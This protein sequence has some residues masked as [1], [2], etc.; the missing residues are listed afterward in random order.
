MKLILQKLQDVALYPKL[1]RCVFHQSQMEFLEYI[2]F[3]EILLID[4][5]KIQAITN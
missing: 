4:P 1:D 2:I 3:N 5:K